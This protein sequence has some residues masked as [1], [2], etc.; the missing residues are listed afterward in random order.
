MLLEDVV[1]GGEC[2]QE[3]LGSNLRW[4]VFNVEIVEGLSRNCLA[5]VSFESEG[6]I[7]DRVKPSSGGYLAFILQDDRENK[8]LANSDF[9]EPQNSSSVGFGV[10][11]LLN[12]EGGKSAFS[13]ELESQLVLFGFVITMLYRAF[14]DCAVLHH[15]CWI[16]AHCYVLVLV[17]V[18]CETLRLDIERKTFTLA[19]GPRLNS[20]LDRTWDLVWVDYLKPFA[21]SFSVLLGNQ[22]AEPEELLLD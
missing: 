22:G 7:C 8:L 9:L 21:R 19:L 3:L 6:F 12:L 18:N 10:S 13:A 2:Q 17:W 15:G 16:E 14:E 4:L 11:W 1:E 20:E 5:H